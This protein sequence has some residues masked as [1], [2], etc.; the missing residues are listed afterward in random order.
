MLRIL[1]D[2]FNSLKPAQAPVGTA[3]R[4][5]TLQLVTAVLL[6]EVVRAD[7]E[8]D[9]SE[10]RAVMEALG[11]RFPLTGPELADL[12][13]LARHTSEHAHDLHSFTRQVNEQMGEAER[14][15]VF[16]MLWGVAYANGRADDH[17]AHLLR[18][19]ADLLHI[20]HQDAIGAKLRAG[21]PAH[22]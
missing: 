7:G 21:R 17:E 18:R 19:L 5:H 10:Q 4:E 2:L 13:E 22:G 8:I 16:E 3:G 9:E 14:I 20:R 11:E 12:F 6:V 1:T 15:Q